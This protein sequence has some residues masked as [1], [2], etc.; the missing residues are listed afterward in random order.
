[1]ASQPSPFSEFQARRETLS[2]KKQKN[3]TKKKPKVDSVPEEWTLEV[4]SLTV[5]CDTHT[6]THTH[7][8]R[9][10]GKKYSG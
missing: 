9:G 1:M 7:T 4:G 10:K 6:H 8:H 3:K 5:A 2:Q